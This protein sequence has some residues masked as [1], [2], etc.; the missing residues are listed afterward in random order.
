MDRS[1]LVPERN[2]QSREAGFQFAPVVACGRHSGVEL[3]ADGRLPFC[4]LV[5]RSETNAQI[6]GHH[7]VLSVV[8]CR[9]DGIGR[10]L[11][12]GTS[13]HGGLKVL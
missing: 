4:L 5:L 11:Y 6:V 1:G 3:A 2:W 8:F 12:A 10:G 13:S 7:R 9:R